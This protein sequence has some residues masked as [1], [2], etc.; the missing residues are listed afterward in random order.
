MNNN[1]TSW[2]AG[3]FSNPIADA[4]LIVGILAII[5]T[6][7]ILSKKGL[8]KLSIKGLS[9]GNGDLER[10]IVRQQIE[11]CKAAVDTFLEAN[12]YTVENRYRARYISELVLDLCTEMIVYNHIDAE[13]D[14]YWRNKAEKAWSIIVK[15]AITPEYKTDAFKASIFEE[16]KKLVVHL[17][18]IRSYYIKRGC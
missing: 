14:F 11:Y 4:V 10:T 8:L 15:Y 13:S 5:I 17:V 1:D 7:A 2:L 12:G 6:L 3:M 18:E 9:I 16:M